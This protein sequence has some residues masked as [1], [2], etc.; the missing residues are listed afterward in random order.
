MKDIVIV[1]TARSPIGKFGGMFKDVSAVELGSNVIKT[2][3]QR[4]NISPESVNQVIFGNV[5]QAGLGQNPA[6]QAAI[7]AGIP[8]SA[9]AMTVNEVC[10]SGLKAVILGRQAIQLGEATTVV[11]GGT[12]N[13][14]QAPLLLNRYDKEAFAPEKLTDSMFFDGLTDAFGHYAMGITAEN[15]ADHHHITREQQDLF[16]YESQQKAAKAQQEGLFDKEISPVTLADGTVVTRDESI[17]P[18]TTLEKLSTLKTVFKREGSVTAGNSS[19]INDGA[20]AL[21]LMDKETAI[22]QNIPYLATIKASAEIGMDPAMMGYAPFYAVNALLEKADLSIDKIDLFELNEAFAAQSLAVVTDLKIPAN[23]ININGGA[24]ALGH[25][26]GASGAR[27]LTT[28]I[29]NLEQT[30]THTGI[31]GLCVGGG[32]GLALLVTRD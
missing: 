3:L 17:R 1:S 20:S 6:R 31:A 29:T 16:A 10:G 13:M 2:A 30:N 19:T 24:I 4:A 23:K 14:T 26:I 7:H 11:V 21:V 15:A 8:H 5:L 32:I 18:Q 28:L 27:I 12:E 22:A 9:P 25:P